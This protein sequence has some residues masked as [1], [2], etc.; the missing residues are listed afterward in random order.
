MKFPERTMEGDVIRTTVG[1]KPYQPV[2]C[3]EEKPVVAEPPETPVP[4]AYFQPCTET[5][6]FI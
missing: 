2:V 5:M 6:P 1:K 4:A 3:D